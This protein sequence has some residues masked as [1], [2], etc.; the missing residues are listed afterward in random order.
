[1]NEVK[2]LWCSRRRCYSIRHWW[3]IYKLKDTPVA[4]III[5]AENALGL[6]SIFDI[7]LCTFCFRCMS[8]PIT[9]MMDTDNC[10]ECYGSNELEIT[11]VILLWLQVMHNI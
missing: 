3:D 9:Y 4:S 8:E 6:I 11:F 10:Q 2:Y 7:N 5:S 1:M